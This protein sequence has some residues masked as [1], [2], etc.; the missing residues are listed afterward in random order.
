MRLRST[1]HPRRGRSL[2]AKDV[3][4]P[5]ASQR[6]RSRRSSTRLRSWPAGCRKTF[7]SQSGCFGVLHAL[8]Q[9]GPCSPSSHG[10]FRQKLIKPQ[11]YRQFISARLDAGGTVLIVDCNLQRPVRSRSD[12]GCLPKAGRPYLTA[13]KANW[14]HRSAC[15]KLFMRPSWRYR[16]P[17]KIP[18]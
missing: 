3:S 6:S 2:A 1:W 14:S 13:C 9:P 15:E 12:E 10:P 11:A 17:Y 4:K 5:G 16:P 7:V 18:T 8:F